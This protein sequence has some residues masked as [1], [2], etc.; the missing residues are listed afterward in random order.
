MA[1]IELNGSGTGLKAVTLSKLI[2]RYPYL[3]T[4]WFPISQPHFSF[5]SQFVAGAST[6]LGPFVKAQSSGDEGRHLP[7]KYS[8]ISL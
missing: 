5:S 6:L 4:L 7:C 8:T 2:T 1:P 3:R